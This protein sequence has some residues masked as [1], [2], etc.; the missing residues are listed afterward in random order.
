MRPV[1][2]AIGAVNNV[3]ERV[4]FFVSTA[5]VAVIVVILF[6]GAVTRYATGLGFN[7]FLELP[8]MLM[9]WLIFPLAGVLMRGTSHIGVEYLPERLP[10]GARRLLRIV[11]FS[12]ATAAG[13]MFCYA[14]ITATLLFRMVGQVTE[15]EW[16]FPIWWIYLSFPVGF[17]ILTLFA[18]EGLLRAAAGLPEVH[19]P[20]KRTE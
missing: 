17:A 1:L 10:P 6:G 2:R 3:L 20:S 12:I 7:V 8:P 11:V 18:I 16:E 13:I 19:V 4:V 9:P 15:M 5:L 14:G